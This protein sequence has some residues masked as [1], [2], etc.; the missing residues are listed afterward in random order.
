MA[1]DW[2]WSSFTTRSNFV[3]YSLLNGNSWKEKK[4]CK[5][6]WSMIWKFSWVQPL[7]SF[8][9]PGHL[10]TLA[11]G[12]LFFCQRSFNTFFSNHR[13]DWSEISYGALQDRGT[14]VYTFGPGYMTKLAVMKIYLKKHL[15]IYFSKITGPIAWK[16]YVASGTIVL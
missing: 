12:H 16:L 14:K 6:L 5:P 9:G 11:K 4:I 13:P 1:L 8:R 15:K 7:W 2:P 10:V 3:S